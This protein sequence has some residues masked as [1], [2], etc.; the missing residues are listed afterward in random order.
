M[1]K[2]KSGIRRI[3]DTLL[4][5]FSGESFIVDPAQSSRES[6]GSPSSIRG[7][8]ISDL[9]TEDASLSVSLSV[10]PSEEEFESPSEEPGEYLE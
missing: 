4:K 2:S 9:Y 10:S 3:A 6:Y 8:L 5:I 1:I 7:K